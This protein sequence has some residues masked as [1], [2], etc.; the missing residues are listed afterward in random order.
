MQ[1]QSGVVKRNGQATLFEGFDGGFGQVG[2]NNA[3]AGA[4]HQTADF[5]FQRELAFLQNG[6]VF[7]EGFHFSKQ[8]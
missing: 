8:M 5:A 2:S 1:F 4:G 3:V 6:D 7:A